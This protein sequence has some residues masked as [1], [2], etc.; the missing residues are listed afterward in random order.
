MSSSASPTLAKH[1][2]EFVLA[3]GLVLA[4]FDIDKGAMVRTYY[5]KAAARNA[6]GVRRRSFGVNVPA[7]SEY[8][9]NHMLPDGAEKLM[10]ARTVFVVNRPRLPV[11]TRFAV[12]AFAL[13]EGTGQW[14]RNGPLR[15]EVST[16]SDILMLNMRTA[17]MTIRYKDAKFVESLPVA[18]NG[19]IAMASVPAEVSDFARRVLPSPPQHRAAAEDAAQ[20]F[21][22]ATAHCF[23]MIQG[24]DGR[25]V[26]VLLQSPA[27]KDPLFTA[28]R[29]AW[30]PPTPPPEP[31][32]ATEE[33][34]SRPVAPPQEDAAD[35][36]AP[37]SPSFSASYASSLGDSPHA[38]AVAV[39]TVDDP[40]SPPSDEATVVPP[41]SEAEAAPV[42][43]VEEA[44]VDPTAEPPSPSPTPSSAP[45]SSEPVPPVAAPI[46][47]PKPSPS[48]SLSP[49]PSS[50]AA[51]QITKLLPLQMLS[52]SVTSLGSPSSVSS[53]SRQAVAEE[54]TGETLYGLCAV[55]SRRD[56][57][58]RRGGRTKAVAIFGPSLAWLEPFFPVLAETAQY[59]CDIP[60]SDPDAVHQ[61]SKV[62]RLCYD[63][64]NSAIPTVTAAVTKMTQLSVE[65][66][67]CCT[68]SGSRE[69]SVTFNAAPFGVTHKMR[70][71]IAA[72]S[73][74]PSLSR[75]CLEGLI[76]IFGLS[77]LHLV[78]AVMTEK[79][80]VV[81]S[82]QGLPTDV[83]EASM[84]LGALGG[85]LQPHFMAQKVFP[86]A[87][88][89]SVDHFLHTPGYVIGTLN[90]IFENRR[91]WNWDVLCDLDKRVIVFA[92]GVGLGLGIAAGG[93]S[94]VLA[95]VSSTL[96]GK[97]NNSSV[98]G[99]PNA[100]E[101]GGDADSSIVAPI[102]QFFKELTVSITQMRALRLPLAERNHNLLLILEEFMQTAVVLSYADGMPGVTAPVAQL[103]EQFM[104]PIAASLRAQCRLTSMM[105]RVDETILFPGESPAT[106]LYTAA[107]RRAKGSDSIAVLGLLDAILSLLTSDNQV[108]LLLRRMTV[109]V[110]GLNPIGMQLTHPSQSVRAAA[111]R[112]LTR[113]DRIPEGEAA[114]AAMNTFLIL[115]YEE[116]CKRA[117][118]L[119]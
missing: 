85:L 74:D 45:P 93:G 51:A 72:K 5:P 114:V 60:G 81:L 2:G 42:A 83:A 96:S 50:V 48:P 4:E 38:E 112:I 21:S 77:F 118:A 88:V 36:A 61:Q 29:R 106:M 49:T 18:E 17:A 54:N 101:T 34:P 23:L 15:P 89:A 11:Y 8:F 76:E 79:K 26:G 24:E 58:A 80:I 55:V 108:R 1:Q 69:A 104:N 67:Q 100:S 90:P 7:Q 22:M 65:L 102:T 116:S 35:D 70:I 37:T 40:A 43:A 16:V 33:E 14:V 115:I 87:S 73:H 107:L 12:Y 110:G 10:V 39:G 109:P 97:K 47:D 56:S 9:A 57:S 28:F 31:L 13:A 25:R 44:H 19:V 41:D 75:F 59:C 99:G 64:V 6:D 103:R 111:T 86:Y 95:S 119:R 92:D 94:G 52:A 20:Q 68:L 105:D 84:A 62:L 71:P 78:W 117:R 113:I 32:F 82:R 30:M 98:S 53:G 46:A 3:N 63:T 91:A 66:T 27:C